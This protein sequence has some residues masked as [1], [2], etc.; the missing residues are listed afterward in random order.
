MPLSAVALK[1]SREPAH[2]PP[3]CLIIYGISSAPGIS[4]A[5]VRAP[6]EAP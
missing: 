1:V 4:V 6:K 2:V 3:W 5:S